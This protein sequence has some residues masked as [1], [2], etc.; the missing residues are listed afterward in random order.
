MS[1]IQAR[2]AAS[3]AGVDNQLPLDQER[4]TKIK[5]SQQFF[6]T[7]LDADDDLLF[8]M[9]AKGCLLD[10]QITQLQDINVLDNRNRKLLNMIKR[11]SIEH[12]DKFR[13][14]L[15]QTQRH[16]PAWFTGNED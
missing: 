11:R 5:N 16:L 1:L 12:Y 15:E 4:Q 6:V 7:K 2:E 3:A 14:R 13:G 8:E 10:S 9:K